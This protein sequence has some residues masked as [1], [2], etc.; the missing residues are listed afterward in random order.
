MT[1]ESK[2]P[3]TRRSAFRGFAEY[4]WSPE[5]ARWRLRLKP[6]PVL[7][8]LMMLG[9][10]CYLSVASVY[11]ANNKWMREIEDTSFREMLLYVFPD[12]IPSTSIHWVPGFVQRSVEHA[13]ESHRKKMANMFFAKAKKSMEAGDI[14]NF[15]NQIFQASSLDPSNMEA[16]LLA[17]QAMFAY[18]RRDDDALDSLEAPLPLMLDKPEYVGEFLRACFVKEQDGRV[19]ALAKNLLAR[20]GVDPRVRE[21]LSIGMATAY[22]YRGDFD[23]CREVITT[24]NL[25]RTRDGYLLL[26][27]IAYERGDVAGAV[28]LLA[29]VAQS[30]NVD[31]LIF[32]NYIDM[33]KEVG[34][35]DGARSAVKLNILSG[36]DKSR[37]R[38][39][40]L[41]LLDGPADAAALREEIA[42]Y[43]KDYAKNETAM[44]QLCE[45]GANFGKTE[46]CGELMADAKKAG[47]PNAPRFELLFIESHLAAGQFEKTVAAVDKIYVENPEWLPK[48]RQVFDCL[49]MVAQMAMRREDM[50]DIIFRRMED[51]TQNLPMPL[52]KMVAKKLVLVGRSEDAMRVI[53]MA[54]EHGGKVGQSLND[55]V[56]IHLSAG[57][58]PSTPALLRRL[59]ATRRPSRVLLEKARKVMAGDAFLFEV[60]RESLI[61][62][63]D[64]L[65]AG[66]PVLPDPPAREPKDKTR[67]GQ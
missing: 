64:T 50:S 17:A 37:S 38:I 42:S 26:V 32:A 35:I 2:T 8:V 22:Y 25:N 21:L 55:V 51:G 62:D 36:G 65:L 57:G 43:R 1:Q 4:V 13:R 46:L 24:G 23:H 27:R 45:Y 40:L 41:E 49:R 54:F 7:S 15:I 10:G 29:P 3:L 48:H 56:D 52:M 14:R 31:P 28:A 44:I 5:A 33:L 58:G 60:D 12:P 59:L 18:L 61:A 20:N 6:V 66:R 39:K 63:I 34:D 11:Y 30:A 9:A 67:G 47:F 19:I 16:R 53:D